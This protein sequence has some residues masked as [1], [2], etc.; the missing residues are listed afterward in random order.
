MANLPVRLQPGAAA[1]RIDGWTNDAEGR[2]VLHGEVAAGDRTAFADAQRACGA[3]ANGTGHDAAAVTRLQQ[4][5][6]GEETD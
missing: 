5:V 3:N 2:P 6:R 1:E 4:A